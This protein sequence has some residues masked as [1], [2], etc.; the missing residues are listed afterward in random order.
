MFK[1]LRSDDWSGTIGVKGKLE[2]RSLIMPACATVAS[3]QTARPSTSL[4][5][6]VPRFPGANHTERL[7]LSGWIEAFERTTLWPAGTNARFKKRSNAAVA[8]VGALRMMIPLFFGGFFGEALREDVPPQYSRNVLS[9]FW[10]TKRNRI[11]F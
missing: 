11:V 6:N 2:S 4:R 1:P 3:T 8:R 5:T 7:E 9:A 10:R